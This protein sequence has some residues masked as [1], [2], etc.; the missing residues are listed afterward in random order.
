ME[1]FDVTLVSPE[2]ILYKGTAR[3]VIIPAK[4]GTMTVLA[5]HA[6]LLAALKNGILKITGESS[7]KKFNIEN[8]FIEV[9]KKT[10]AERQKGISFVN[11]FVRQPVNA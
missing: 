9:S 2:Q 4:E 5:R 10:D 11:I 8:G 6:P 7:E 3:E 1:T